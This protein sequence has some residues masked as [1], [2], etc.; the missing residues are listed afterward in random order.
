MAGH[1]A[2]VAGA[3]AELGVPIVVTEEGAA[4]NGR[5][6]D[7]VLAALPDGTPIL[8]KGVFAAPDNPDILAAVEATGRS[9]V[10][11]VGLETDVCVAH[12]A[13]RFQD[14]GKR[15]AAVHDALFSPGPGPRERPGPHDAGR[16]RPAVGEG[17]GLRLGPLGR[18]DPIPQARPARPWPPPPGFSL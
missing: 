6:V 16:D 8:P 9:T 2:W 5:T 17:A 13:L 18:G 10:V 11:L 4:Y 3:A 14:G 15:V 7:A 1:C 12:S